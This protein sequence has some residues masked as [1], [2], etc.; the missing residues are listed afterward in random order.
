MFVLSF[1]IQGMGSGIQHFGMLGIPMNMN[2][3]HPPAMGMPMSSVASLSNSFM[4]IHLQSFSSMSSA[5]HQSLSSQ[6]PTLGTGFQPSSFVSESNQSQ[7]SSNDKP[8]RSS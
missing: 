4:P 8:A 2:L 5:P 7:L 1:L 6:L 3:M